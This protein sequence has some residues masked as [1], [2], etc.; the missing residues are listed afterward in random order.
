MERGGQLDTIGRAEASR[1]LIR[2]LV[3]TILLAGWAS[4]VRA[5]TPAPNPVPLAR[6]LTEQQ[7]WSEVVRLAAETPVHSPDLDYYYG[8]ALAQLGRLDEARA[9]LQKGRR[10][11]PLDKRFPLELAGVEF[12]QKRYTESTKWLRRALELDPQD[13]YANDFLGSVYFLQG[14]LEAALKYW[15]RNQRPVIE[16]LRSEPEPRLDPVV[17]DRAFAFAPASTLQLSELLAT[18]ARIQGLEIF[19][20]YLFDL[21]ARDDNKFDL[22]FRN[23]ELNGWGADKWMGL[24]SFF[25]GAFYQTVYPEYFNI[26]S[27]ATNVVSLVRWDA[28]K[29]RL[30]ASLSGPLRR[31]A[32]WRYRI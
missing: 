11:R 28:E 17:L 20:S 8:L 15:N 16:S 27:T 12:K 25:R 24:V 30:A 7:R 19:P 31:D 2:F 32:K 1:A 5:Q 3:F 4:L 10:L 9:A 22:T 29:R 21:N 23:R 26:G 18:R 14:N 13:A 6:E